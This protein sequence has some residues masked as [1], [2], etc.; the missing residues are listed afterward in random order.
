MNIELE[1]NVNVDEKERCRVIYA[2]SK[3]A[4]QLATC[5]LKNNKYIS[6]LN[7]IYQKVYSYK[8]LFAIVHICVLNRRFRFAC[9]Y[10]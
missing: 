3:S 9:R 4:G 5:N 8:R 2:R 6:K 7:K 10:R 1:D